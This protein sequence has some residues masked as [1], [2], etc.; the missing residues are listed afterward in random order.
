MRTWLLFPA[1]IAAGAAFP[2]VARAQPGAGS[3]VYVLE[4]GASRAASNVG[5]GL[6][7]GV[8]RKQ[9]RVQLGAAFEVIVSPG[10]SSGRYYESAV[11]RDDNACRDRQSGESVSDML[12]QGVQATPAVVGS[13]EFTPIRALPVVFG[14]GYRVGRAYGPFGLVAFTGPLA[15]SRTRFRVTMTAGPGYWSG[16]FGV[17]IPESSEK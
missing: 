17:T 8:A 12:C 6:F 4:A 5:L 9:N 11:Q 15:N 14:G 10:V 3:V 1:V 2:S 13:L 7:A 16:R